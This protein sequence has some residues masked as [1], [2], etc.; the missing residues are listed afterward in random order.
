MKITLAGI[1]AFVLAVTVTQS[2]ENAPTTPE[3]AASKFDNDQVFE[4][5]LS[6]LGV[7]F[8]IRCANDSS[9]NKLTLTPSGLTIDNSPITCE[10]DG[11]VRR[12]EVADLNSDG[13][14]E[15]Y[16]YVTSA[17]SGSYASLV[18]Y[19]VNHGKSLTPVFL[20][21]LTDNKK[22][23][24]GFMGHDEFAVVETTLVRRFP[25]YN[26]DDT[27]SAPSGKTRQIQYKLKAGEAGWILTVDKVIEY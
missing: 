9:L 14:P 10:I 17:G 26:N 19:A 1:C 23:A 21:E 5:T 16:I 24:H 25:I 13:S 27:N 7:T 4:Q 22:A 6:L 3:T 11:T 12:A 8:E 18:A 20:P 15:I 2:A